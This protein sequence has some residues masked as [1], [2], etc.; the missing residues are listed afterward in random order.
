MSLAPEQFAE[1]DRR[2]ELAVRQAFAR[3]LRR[4]P[5][6]TVSQWAE[7]HRVIAAEEGAES[8]RWSNARVPYL[9]EI[10]DCMSP[11]HPCETVT[12]EKC[13]Q[14]GFSQIVVNCLFFFA[15]QAPGPSMLIQ[16]TIDLARMFIRQ[17]LNTAAEATPRIAQ[18]FNEQ[19]SRDEQGSST[20]FKKFGGGFLLIT[21]ANSTAG[22]RS[23]T[24]RYMAKDEWDE[25]PDDIDGQ[26]DPDGMANARLTVY[27]GA[28]LSKCLQGSTPTTE[29]RSRT[30]KA[31]LASDQRVF[32]V[33]CPDCG[34]RQELIFENLKFNR[35]APYDARYQCQA[36]GVPIAH[37][38][39][40]AMLAAGSW[41]ATTRG[42]GR[43]PGF[44]IS[45]LMSP[46]ITWDQ[47][48][49]A[50]NLARDDQQ[51]L[52]VFY[53]TVIGRPW[54][55]EGDAPAWHVLQKRVE[56]WKLRTVPA[57]ALVLTCG[58]D[59]QKDE[60]RYQVV[61]W[62]P[63]M[64][65]WAVDY[66]SIPGDTANTGLDGPWV[67]LERLRVRKFPDAFGGTRAIDM[68]AVDAGYNTQ[69][70]YDFVR[71]RPGVMAVKGMPKPD[72]LLLAPAKKEETTQG[73]K[74]R[75]RGVVLWRVGT[76]RLKS[77]FY[78][79]LRRVPPAVENADYPLGYCHYSRETEE[80]FFQEL[81]AEILAPKRGPSGRTTL[82][83]IEKGPNH[84]LDTR[85][86]A[87]AAAERV[88]VRRMTIGD[89]QA[90]ADK[91]EVPSEA[92]QADLFALALQRGA[93]P[94]AGPARATGSTPARPAM[95]DQEGAAERQG[96]PPAPLDKGRSGVRPDVGN[97]ADT[98]SAP[99][100]AEP[101]DRMATVE[102]P[103]AERRRPKRKRIILP[104][105]PTY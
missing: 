53:N 22:L 45:G 35:E 7:R 36:C 98:T 85:I 102:L 94:I 49:Q 54:R 80:G 66:G 11:S 70:V 52:R 61:G 33:P 72:A 2:G 15:D 39:K 81:T 29:S 101:T 14:T 5:E 56:D 19:K 9:A 76:W 17:K 88:G 28:G 75:R 95:A 24:I 86:Y 91:L 31:Y 20:F 73:G 93:K 51:A 83:W 38:H 79:L 23:H 46:F 59:V 16:P 89:W 69:A 103:A 44:R 48:A 92:T 99:P 8:G 87:T 40:A 30:H 6:L 104:R 3:A 26:G 50:F 71:R 58:V 82:Q 55:E 37:H 105:R 4:T 43:Q 68:M 57:G 64:T 42:P 77:E 32:E 97:G 90:L 18:R 25:W 41:N 67:E 13:A 100:L 62:G 84:Y 60:L 47:I 12:V 74:L 10:M 1:F 21:G 78:G 65:S 63:G 34:H 27:R 96:D